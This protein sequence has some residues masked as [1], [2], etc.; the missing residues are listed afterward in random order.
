MIQDNIL[1]LQ[2]ANMKARVAEYIS[3]DEKN[4]IERHNFRHKM[5]IIADLAENG[6]YSD[7]L[8]FIREYNDTL[9]EIPVKRYCQHIL[10]DAILATYLSKA[11]NKQI[12]I[13]ARINFPDSLPVNEADLATA[14]ANALE[15]A[16]HAC[17]KLPPSERLIEIK[18]LN[19]PQFM[20]QISNHF[21]GNI[22]FNKDK[23]PVSTQ[24]GHGFGTRSIIAFC[25]KNNA[26][27]EFSTDNSTFYLRIIFE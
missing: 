18:V 5:N 17:E 12:K 20:I 10:I 13:H 11:E 3:S 23:L 21:D 22:T 26:Y 8:T 19:S 4:R 2:V 7:L 15:N 14:F 1:L 9:D 25:K 6:Q 24:D 16:I 27:Y